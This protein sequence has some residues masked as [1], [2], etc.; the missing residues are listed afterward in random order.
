LSKREQ[1][2]FEL[3]CAGRSAPF[4]AEQLFIAPS[5]VSTHIKRIYAKLEVNSRQELLSLVNATRL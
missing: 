3:L 5:T 4:I 2:V 1:E